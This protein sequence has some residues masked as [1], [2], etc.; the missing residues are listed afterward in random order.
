MTAG[1]PRLKAGSFGDISAKE[2]SPKKW[3]ARVLY[4]DNE[5][6]RRE[7]TK[8]A[9]SR[10]GAVNLLKAHIQDDLAPHLE[11]A[12]ISRSTS[13]AALGEMFLEKKTE[14]GLAPNSIDTYRSNL[15]HI[16]IPAIGN[17]AVTE[18]TPMR[19]Q[20]FINKVSKSNGP[21]AAKGCRSVL[22]GMLSMAVVNGV[23]RENPVRS[24]ERIKQKV[25]H[26]GSTALNPLELQ[27]MREL[28]QTDEA[29][30]FR[31]VG[32]LWEFMSYTGCRIG[33][34]LALRDS[35]V[36]PAA[37]MVT[38][39]PSVSR[40]K[41]KGLIIWEPSKSRDD[42]SF[43]WRTIVI[44][45]RAM[46]IVIARMGHPS[47]LIFP[48]MEGYLRDPNNTERDWRNERERLKFDGFT[49]HGFRKTVATVLDQAGL[50]ARDIAEYLG[51]KNPSMTQDVYMAK[52]TQSP[53]A[54]ATLNSHFIPTNQAT[55][56][57]ELA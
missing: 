47:G 7:A 39:G 52:N 5:G 38:L 20:D 35:H 46:D 3:R 13:I 42:E 44:P 12:S 1:R 27:R 34:A 17:M 25:G 19:L 31:G 53:R 33:E 54:A 37:S 14:L 4:R 48:S 15:H 41:G 40:V 50:S 57:A 2:L 6:N 28:C 24:L 22:S 36:V 32:P 29:L 56:D 51:H 8:V 9:S 11:K 10:N 26:R 16:V 43:N 21:G 18:A 49:P 30:L 55:L 23:I 45:D